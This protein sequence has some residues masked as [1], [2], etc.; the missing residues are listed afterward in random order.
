MRVESCMGCLACSAMLLV[1]TANAMDFSDAVRKAQ[2]YDPVTQGAQ[3]AYRAGLEKGKQGTALYLPQINVTG[4]YNYLHINSIANLPLGFPNA[5]LVGNSSGYLHGFGVTL[6]QPI[7]NATAWAGKT[8]LHDQ[9][10]LAAI[11]F[12]SANQNLILRVAQAYFGELMAEDSLELTREQ[13]A[14]TSQQLASAQARFKAGK[15]NITDVDDAQ[16]SYDGIV[17]QEIAATNSLAIQQDL[18]KSIVG[19]TPHALARVPDSFTPRPPVPDVLE[20][21]TDRGQQTNPTIASARIQIDISNA[22]VRKY[23]LLG[24]PQLNL[25]V[26][27]QDMRQS[28]TLPILVAPDSSRQ[29]IVGVQLSLPLFTGGADESKL[30][31]ALDNR[32]QAHYQLQAAVLNTNVQIKQQF[33]NVEIGVQQ[34]AALKQAVISAKSSLDATT[35]G[36]KVGVRT[37]LDVLK[38]QQQYFSAVQNLD[39]GRYQY[40]L[41]TLN[42]K[43]VA[44]TLDFKDVQAVNRYLTGDAL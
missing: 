35:L 30:R 9:A 42:L 40:L 5:V 12:Q 2:A 24:R 23:S 27:Y 39:A 14:A 7:Y 20:D 26:S 18:F 13:K 32:E 41:S 25:F 33:L 38:A 37:T 15:T 3:Y 4:N 44:G 16:A 28:G 6:T 21:W 1:G 11:Q 29:T 19:E 43:S 8:E 34:I 31:E 36:Q 22:E 10:R 17:A